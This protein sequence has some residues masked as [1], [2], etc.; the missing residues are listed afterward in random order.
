[1]PFIY[2][3]T[4]GQGLTSDGTGVH[5]DNCF[6]VD[7]ISGGSTLYVTALEVFNYISGKLTP[8]TQ[9]LLLGGVDM[10]PLKG[11][12]ADP[13]VQ[14]SSGHAM[15]AGVLYCCK[16][17]VQSSVTISTA[18][19]YVTAAGAG[20]S[21][22]VIGLYSIASGVAT[23]VASTTNLA[24]TGQLGSIGAVTV[25]FFAPYATPVAGGSLIVA[26]LIGAGTT[27]PA[28][29]CA[30]NAVSL[31]T[32]GQDGTLGYPYFAYGTG[33]TALPSTLTLNSTNCTVA[34]PGSSAVIIGLN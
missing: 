19:F 18:E 25:N 3:P 21:N 16:A 27:M 10:G 30:S 7:R 5:D 12:T 8:P 20:M 26:I 31:L 24:G 33:L 28:F 32:M 11:L 13:R 14:A 4:P 6:A 29:T 1:M 2:S 15:V 34:N 17:T 9:N 23:L 22:C